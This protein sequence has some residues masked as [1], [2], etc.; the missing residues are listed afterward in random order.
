MA[1]PDE[2]LKLL[3][4]GRI[5]L[6]GV[7]RVVEALGLPEHADIVRGGRVGGDGPGMG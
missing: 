5:V 1:L 4:L 7:D 2:F 3:D 6:E